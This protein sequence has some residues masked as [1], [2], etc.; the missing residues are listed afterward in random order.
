MKKTKTVESLLYD[1][2]SSVIDPIEKS[3]ERFLNNILLVRANHDTKQYQYILSDIKLNST[4]FFERGIFVTFTLT[5]A[6]TFESFQM[7]SY[8][9][10]ALV[11]ASPN[12]RRTSMIG[13]ICSYC[14]LK[15]SFNSF[16][17]SILYKG[18]SR[19]T[20]V[21]ILMKERDKPK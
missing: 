1:R 21:G 17:A 8:F 19:G 4:Q 2:C 10:Q 3:I 9:S 11:F 5:N 7:P 6:E 15:Q 16:V 20:Y 14:N 13:D 18:G 12:E